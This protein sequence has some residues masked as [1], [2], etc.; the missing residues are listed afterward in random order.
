MGG[1]NRRP[2]RGSKGMGGVF[3]SVAPRHESTPAT[4]FWAPSSVP[5]RRKMSG[6]MFGM[7][8]PLNHSGIH[9]CGF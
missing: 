2:Y 3:R 8:M 5:V 6:E 9:V 4:M 1:T 7:L